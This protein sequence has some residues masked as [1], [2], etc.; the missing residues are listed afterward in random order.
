[1]YFVRRKTFSEPPRKLWF[2]HFGKASIRFTV[3]DPGYPGQLHSWYLA[4]SVTH[5]AAALNPRA[6]VG[7]A[8]RDDNICR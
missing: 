3:A 4:I 8:Q 7:S 1:M 2:Q 6:G 5:Q